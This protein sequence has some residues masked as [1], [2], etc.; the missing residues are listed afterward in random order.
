M[1]TGGF[2]GFEIQF[3]I[4]ADLGVFHFEFSNL[5]FYKRALKRPSKL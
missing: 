4:K 1:R 2:G 5:S 3:F